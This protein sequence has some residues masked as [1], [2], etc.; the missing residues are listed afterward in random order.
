M[1]PITIIG[2]SGA[3]LGAVGKA[4]QLGFF[5]KI[6]PTCLNKTKQNYKQSKEKVK[7]MFEKIYDEPMVGA[8][9]NYFKEDIKILAKILANQFAEFG[10]DIVEDICND[11]LRSNIYDIENKERHIEYIKEGKKLRREAIEHKRQILLNKINTIIKKN[12]NTRN[13]RNRERKNVEDKLNILEELKDCVRDIPYRTRADE[14]DDEIIR[15]L[16]CQCQRDFNN[17][18]WSECSDKC[19]DDVEEIV[20]CME[21]PKPSA[22]KV[23]PELVKPEEVIPEEKPVWLLTDEEQATCAEPIP[24][25][26]RTNSLAAGRSHT[27]RRKFR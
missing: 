22:P 27:G 19:C 6:M 10:S 23:Y 7:N 8:V 25:L 2:V 11:V 14:D 4:Y 1:D 13:L 3:T 5:D 12:G 17:K 21:E 9:Y 18:A 24:P 20:E 16:E 26:Q 15:E